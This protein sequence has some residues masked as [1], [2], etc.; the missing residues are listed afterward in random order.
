M[1]HGKRNI[2][3]GRHAAH[4]DATI[5]SLVRSLVLHKRIQTT[6]AKA[7]EARRVADKLITW[8][9]KGGLHQRRLAYSV[10]KDR[11]LVGI[12][13]KD[14]GPLFTDRNGGYT[15]VIHTRLRVGDNAQ[16]AILEWTEKK[17]EETEKSKVKS[18]K[19]GPSKIEREKVKTEEIKPEVKKEPQIKPKEEAKRKEPEKQKPTKGFLGGLRKLF[20]RKREGQ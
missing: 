9:K 13:F 17:Q 14:I 7:K 10:L 1:R 8:A 6:L 16:L 2:K 18:K 11:D 5:I 15:R 3:F 12:L 19:R 20:N 4:R